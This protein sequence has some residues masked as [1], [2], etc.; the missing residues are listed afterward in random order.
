MFR[1]DEELR[2][3]ITERERQSQAQR[4]RMAQEKE[5]DQRDEQEYEKLMR[6]ERLRMKREGFVDK[7]GHAP[8]PGTSCLAQ[9]FLN[10]DRC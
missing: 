9:W 4:A 6:Q 7:V 1:R 2:D 10:S 8:G 5:R 3:Q